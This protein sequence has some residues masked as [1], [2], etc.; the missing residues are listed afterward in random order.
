MPI[1]MLDW[2]RDPIWSNGGTIGER[3]LRELRLS[4]NIH[5]H[6]ITEI[7][8]DDSTVLRCLK[9][10]RHL[11]VATSEIDLD[12]VGMRIRDNIAEEEITAYRLGSQLFTKNINQERI[13][14]KASN[15]ELCETITDQ[16]QG[17]IKGKVNGQVRIRNMGTYRVKV[18]PDT[19]VAQEDNY[20]SLEANTY[21]YEQARYS[22]TDCA[23]PCTIVHSVINNQITIILSNSL[24]SKVLQDISLCVP[25]IKEIEGK[26]LQPNN[27]L[28][29]CT[30]DMEKGLS[31]EVL[32]LQPKDSVKLQVSILNSNCEGLYGYLSVQYSCTHPDITFDAK[33]VQVL[34][35]YQHAPWH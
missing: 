3:Y 34:R 27:L 32:A 33:S 14:S 7:E 6:N 20:M 29:K 30:V 5:K 25:M 12:V 31:W 22:S 15:I 17:V 10:G 24:E 19:K 35:K 23:F 2:E 21:Y 18:R 13:S 8:Y 9:I 16:M 28:H 4:H 1:L 11:V 26:H